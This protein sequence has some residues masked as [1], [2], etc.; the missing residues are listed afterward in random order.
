[1]NHFV[2]GATGLVGR[3]L[4]GELLARDAEA[5][6]YVLVRRRSEDRLRELLGI[7]SA[8]D[9]VVPVFGDVLAPDLGIASFDAPIDHLWHVA[10][11]YH[12]QVDWETAR[13]TNVEGTRNAVRFA[14]RHRVGVFHHTSTNGLAGSFAGRF[15]EAMLDE[16]QRVDHPYFATKLEAE[17]V[18][19]SELER[20][21]RVYRPG[22]VVGDSRTGEMDK[23]D[24]AY[25]FFGPIRA[26]RRLPRWL[27]LVGPRGRP[28]NL[29]PVD[30]CARA[31]VHIGLLPEADLPGDTFHLVD[32]RVTAGDAVNAVADAAGAPRLA[33]LVPPSITH[34]VARAARRLPGAEAVR[35]WLLDRLGIPGEALE[36]RDF[37][38][39]FDTA[40]TDRVLEGTG[41][42]LPAFASYAGRLY[43]YW[44]RHLDPVHP[45]APLERAV[46]GRRVMVTGASS[47][48]GRA[49]A[50]DLGRAGARVLLVARR[51]GELEDVQAE[52]R[53]GGGEAHVHAADLADAADIDRLVREVLDRHGGV[54]VLVNNAG[55]SIRRSIRRSYGRLHDYRRTM[56]VNYFAAVQL[57]LGFLPGMRE[58]RDGHLVN[59]SSIGL[60]ADMSR[61]TAYNPSKAAVDAFSRSLA[62]E[63]AHE[64]VAVTTVYM[65]L[66]RT[67]MSGPTEAFRRLPGLTCEQAADLVAKA[68]VERPPRVTTALGLL[69]QAVGVL[70]PRFLLR[71][72]R[73]EHRL[74]PESQAAR[75]PIALADALGPAPP[76]VLGRQA[77]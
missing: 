57:T 63:V 5:T 29:V 76:D 54:D 68:L 64:G 6:V 50:R 39:D 43:R 70:W 53:A 65:P 42:E 77:A 75:Q 69:A 13:A 60:Q 31:M 18:V 37:A 15:T 24:G 71:I 59:I 3:H 36:W 20:P 56:D 10:A 1:V 11:A 61:F 27:P 17:K 23:L 44:D 7:W 9:R 30:F 14:N 38:A 41:I 21:L 19:R 49:V 72:M 55:R 67:R 45:P 35:T 28:A 73:L 26:A 2:T 40:N 62:A 34:A 66:V 47:G 33:V 48:I 52:I 12:L 8:G 25:Y 32:T 58:R 74:L 16:G 4:V 46:A 22:P 51:Q